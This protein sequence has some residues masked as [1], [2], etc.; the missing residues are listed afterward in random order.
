MSYLYFLNISYVISHI[1]SCIILMKSCLPG[2]W[3]NRNALFSLADWNFLV[4]LDPAGYSSLNI[5]LGMSATSC[6]NCN[7]F[8]LR[9]LLIT[10]YCNI[11]FQ[12]RNYNHHEKPMCMIMSL[13]LI[14]SLKTLNFQQLRIFENLASKWVT[15]VKFSSQLSKDRKRPKRILKDICRKWD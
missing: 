2:F 15:D 12:T 6:H 11:Y 4:L 7:Y 9:R 14:W 1:F 5:T 13:V 10:H 3:S 8:I